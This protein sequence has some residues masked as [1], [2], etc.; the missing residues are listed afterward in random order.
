LHEEDGYDPF[1]LSSKEGLEMLVLSRRAGEA[2]VVGEDVVLTVL[3][4]QG[5][6]IR[7]GIKAPA[8]VAVDRQEVHERRRQFHEDPAPALRFAGEV[9]AWG[10]ME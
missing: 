8:D 2:I 4:V 10:R 9:A 1:T 6:T 5:S 3:S 7:L